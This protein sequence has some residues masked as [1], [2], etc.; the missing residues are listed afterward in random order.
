[1]RAGEHLS[2]GVKRL[3]AT[4]SPVALRRLTPL[5][6]YYRRQASTLFVV[7]VII[8]VVIIMR[9]GTRGLG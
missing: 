1:M 4:A 3:K 5:G 9:F 6:E 2:G 7:L 8:I